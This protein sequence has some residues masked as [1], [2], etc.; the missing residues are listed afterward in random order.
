MGRARRLLRKVVRGVLSRFRGDDGRAD[1]DPGKRSAPKQPQKQK[2]RVYKR[3]SNQNLYDGVD[4]LRKVEVERLHAQVVSDI[5]RR[6]QDPTERLR[7]A[8]VVSSSARWNC[9]LLFSLLERDD[10][11]SPRIV[12]TRPEHKADVDRRTSYYQAQREFFARIDPD[13]VELYDPVTGISDPVE[14]LDADVIFFQMPWGMK[15]FPR[16][17]AG[18]A[19]SAYMHYGFMVMANHEMHYNIASFHSYLW[20][21]FTQTEGHR[22]MHLE[23]DP[24]A[25]EKLI[26]TGY[27]K[28]DVY[29]EPPPEECEVWEDAGGPREGRKRVIYAP[30]HSLGLD[31]L[32]MSTFAWT[33]DLLLDLVEEHR[34][35]QWVYKPHPSLR[36][37]VERN[38][39]MTAEQY[40]EYEG[41]WASAPNATVFDAGG[42][43]DLFRTSDALVTCCGSFLAEYLPTGKPIIWLVSDQSVGLNQVGADL[44]EGFY[45][46]HSRQEFLDTFRQVVLEGDDPLASNRAQL[47]KEL[48]PQGASA[49]QAVLD[50]L[51]ARLVP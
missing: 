47:A 36:F 9:D 48:F 45:A 22:R 29:D 44:A 5:R 14:D 39:L 12:L 7:V 43:F 28:L 6:L 8:F 4:F 38:D 23:H 41:A 31:N 27:P 33:H 13:F 32:G 11:M 40:A 24:S 26:V 37:S 50:V 10:R 15:D 16:R 42:Y 46:V 35:L 20:A 17:V 1:D 49:S 51:R 34:D 3:A 18:R 19:L 21:Y 25:L 2:P 30:H